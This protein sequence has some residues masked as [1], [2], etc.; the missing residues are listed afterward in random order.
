MSQ[1]VL[2]IVQTDMNTAS[3]CQDYGWARALAG[4]GIGWATAGLGRSTQQLLRT[5]VQMS[6]S[7]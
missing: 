6:V 3:L 4:P 2:N 5:A 1:N 7:A